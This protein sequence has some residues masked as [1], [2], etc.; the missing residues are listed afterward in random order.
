MDGVN[1]SRMI[2]RF[3]IVIATSIVLPSA[4]AQQ[5]SPSVPQIIVSGSAEI[6]LPATKASFSIG[7]MTSASSANAANEDNSRITKSVIEA[8]HGA[9]LSQADI[10]GSRLA[11]S[12]RW[13]YE[14]KSRRPKRSVFEATNTIK[15]Q[16][17]NLA[18]IGTYIDAALSAGATDV[19]DVGFEA[20]DTDSARRQALAQAV[21]S[22]RSDAESIA[23]AGGGTLGELLSLSTERTNQ[24]AGVNLE[25]IVVTATRRAREQVSTDVIPSQIKV[26]ARIDARWRFVPAS[27]AK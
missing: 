20:K 13:D 6:L 11:V 8:L 15:I 12:P 18:L 14:E 16:T 10:A 22:A 24:A 21:S 23:R 25:E 5:A 27:L 7:I 4:W 9:H 26:T 17:E 19:S 3:L 1:R 2:A